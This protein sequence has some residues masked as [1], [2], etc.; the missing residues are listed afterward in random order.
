M[1]LEIDNRLNVIHHDTFWGSLYPSSIVRY[2]EYFI[3][4]IRGGVVATTA[5]T[6]A[7]N[8]IRYF[9]PE[10]HQE[11]E[12]VEGIDWSDFLGNPKEKK[13]H[14]QSIEEQ[15]IQPPRD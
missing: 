5:E 4:G 8:R 11:K 6:L 2:H 14:N 12:K 7:P 15:P 3:F 1:V 13:S 9:K 10:K